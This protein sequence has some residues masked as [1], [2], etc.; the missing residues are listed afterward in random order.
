MHGAIEV[1]N[2]NY[3]ESHFDDYTDL[4]H[5]QVVLSATF[6]GNTAFHGAAVHLTLV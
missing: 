6:I 4:G 3:E 2:S 1:D 5:F